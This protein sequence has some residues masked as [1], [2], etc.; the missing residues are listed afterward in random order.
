MTINGSLP[1]ATAA[2]SGASGGSW[3]R[4]SSRAKKCPE[5]TALP[6]ELVA[7][8]L[9]QHWIAC[10]E[11]VEDGPL[12][13]Q[14]FDLEFNLAADLRQGSEVEGEDDADHVYFYLSV[15]Q[16]FLCATTVTETDS[17]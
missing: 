6:R 10:F 15:Q 4:S 9:S 5:R 14:N 1:E 3:D 8:G 2:G 12:R 13:S 17:E 7:D 11:G 16:A